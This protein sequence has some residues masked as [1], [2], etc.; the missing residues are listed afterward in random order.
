MEKKEPEAVKGIPKEWR[1]ANPE[2]V[3][4]YRENYWVKKATKQFE[5]EKHSK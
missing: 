4:E 5:A 1:Q 2:K 3:K